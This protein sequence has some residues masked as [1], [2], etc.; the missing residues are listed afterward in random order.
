MPE[1]VT[2]PTVDEHVARLTSGRVVQ[3]VAERTGTPPDRTAAILNMYGAECRYGS[4]LITKY[5]PATGRILEVGAGLG[6]LSSY[7]RMLGHD[8]TALE[9]CGTGFDF[10]REIQAVVREE[11][12]TE[13]PFLPIPA[14]EL[15]P[16]AHGVFQFIF[17]VNVLEHIRDLPRAMHGMASV[18]APGGRMWHTCPNYFFPYDPHFALPLIPLFP[19]ATGFLLPRR[20]SGSELWRSLNFITYFGLKRL[21]GANSLNTTFLVGTMADAFA[22]LDSDHEFAGRHGRM[23]AYVYRVLKAMGGISAV[24][25]LPAALSSPMMVEMERKGLSA[26]NKS[27]PAG[28]RSAI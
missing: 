22:R 7:L 4:Y 27:R 5:L 6:M 28:V 12:G 17:S 20:I 23:A 21:A 2:P 9:P 18:L 24:R 15:S 13:V 8:I 16:G 11:T 19:E 1:R 3:R 25:A 10:F 14:E 26:E